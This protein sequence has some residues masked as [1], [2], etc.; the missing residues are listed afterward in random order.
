MSLIPQIPSIS[1][2][3]VLAFT[4]GILFGLTVCTSSCLPYIAGYIA[5]TGAGFRKGTM[6][7]LFFSAGRLVAYT[8]VGAIVAVLGGVFSFFLNEAALVPIQQYSA[9][10]FAAITILIG[11]YLL[12]KIKAHK[13]D[14]NHTNLENAK[15]SKKWRGFDMG[16]FSLGLSRGL[17]LCT[18]LVSLMLYSLPFATP[19]DSLF[20][21]VLFGLGTTISPILLLGGATGWLLSKAPLFRKWVAIAGAGILIALGVLNLVTA[22]TGSN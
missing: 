18:P 11:V 9:Y 3:F 20:V 10:A 17:V 1:N 6:I 16:A 22:I 4:V 15:A 14:F 19:I 21:A 5:G 12:Y 2:P 13:C 8:I 7:T